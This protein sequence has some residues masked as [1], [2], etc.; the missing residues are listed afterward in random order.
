MQFQADLLNAEVVRPVNAE[1]TVMG[2]A[3]MAGLGSGYWSSDEE[4]FAGLKVEKTFK[5]KMAESDR[6][7]L[8]ADWTK[9]CPPCDGLAQV[10]LI[11]TLPN[12]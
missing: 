6:S 12:F 1:A 2:A 4:A 11:G 7:M 3:Y 8:Y 9:S 10:G 5:P